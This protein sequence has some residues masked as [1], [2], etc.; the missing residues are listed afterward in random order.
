[1][2]L[3]EE[4]AKLEEHLETEELLREI[5]LLNLPMSNKLKMKLN[6]HFNYDIQN[7]IGIYNEIY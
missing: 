1:M 4:I 7:N 2:R 3:E 6:E 5:W